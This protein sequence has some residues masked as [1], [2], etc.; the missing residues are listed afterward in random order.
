[1]RAISRP[2]RECVVGKPLDGKRRCNCKHCRQE[3]RDYRADITPF[4]SIG[5][6]AGLALANIVA[7]MEKPDAA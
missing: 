4:V 1:M 6:A 7:K 3:R 2:E 5:E